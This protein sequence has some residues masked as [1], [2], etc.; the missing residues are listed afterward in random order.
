MFYLLVD[1]DN[2]TWRD[3]QWGENI[4]HE[5]ENDNYHFV[6]Y[7]SPQ[8]ACYMYPCYE[9]TRNPKI[10]TATGENLNR[11]DGF[12]SKFA[13]LTTIS[14]LP[15]T[16]PTNEQRITFGILCAMNLVLNPLFRD[17]ALAY[18]K[19]DDQTKETAHEVNSQLVAQQGTGIPE[20]YEYIDCCHAVLASVMLDDPALFAANAAHRAYHD[21]FELNIP[22]S[23]EEVAQIVDVVSMKDIATL[24]E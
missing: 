15:I 14:E 11:D 22:L 5:E 16:L 17:W 7:N 2:K 20:E 18:L 12:R 19:G 13:K 23:L 24:L 3:T 6:V 10:W 9:G 4:T 1:Q 8:A 21:S